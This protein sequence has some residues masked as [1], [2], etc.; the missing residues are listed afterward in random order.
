MIRVVIFCLILLVPALGFAN[1]ANESDKKWFVDLGGKTVDVVGSEKSLTGLR[2]G[3]VLPRGINIGAEAFTLTKQTKSAENGYN[4]QQ[5]SYNYFG[6]HIEYSYKLNERFSLIP[7]FS[8]GFG[9]GTYEEQDGDVYSSVE[10]SYASVEPSVTL[11]VRVIQ[12]MWLNVG[13]SYF[14]VGDEPGFK[15]GAS[16]NIFARYMW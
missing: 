1:S 4:R 6:A 11:S 16:L 15:N 12:S 3:A 9:M 8:A 14:L 13:G 7:G 5:K 2:V 10:K